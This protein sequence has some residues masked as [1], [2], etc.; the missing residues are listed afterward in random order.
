MNIINLTPHTISLVNASNEI[1]AS[2]PSAGTVRVATS[3]TIIGELAGFPI[4]KTVLGN[5]TGLPDAEDGTVYLVSA[6]V[7]QALP[8]RNDLV[9]PDS[10]PTA[11]RENGLIVGVR[12]WT[13]Y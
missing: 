8:N 9:V 4:R 3:Q 5:V 7:Q 10:G 6:M 13:R 12:G 1:V 2:F 11:Y